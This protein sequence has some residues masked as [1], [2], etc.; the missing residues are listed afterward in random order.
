MPKSPAGGA[1]S[2]LCSE[3]P[4]RR[5]VLTV[6]PATTQ[7]RCGAKWKNAEFWH[8]PNLLLRKEVNHAGLLLGV[9]GLLGIW[10]NRSFDRHWRKQSR[11]VARCKSRRALIG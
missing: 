11:L 1:P 9:R 2:A 7:T 10:L 5:R 8:E 4:R 6:S 3:D